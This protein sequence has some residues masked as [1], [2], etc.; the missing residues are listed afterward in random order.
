VESSSGG[1]RRRITSGRCSGFAV[2][3]TTAFLLF[4]LA[5]RAQ[6]RFRLELF[7]GNSWSAP[8]TLK[9]D[10]SGEERLSFRARWLTH[11]S[12]DAHYFAARV[13]L[14]SGRKGWELQF[15]HHKIYLTN[16]PAEIEK[17][18]VSHGWNLLTIQRASHGRILDW[19]IGA[20][21]VIAHAEGTIR[22]R[23]VDEG[24][25][26]FGHGYYVSGAAALMGVGKSVPIWRGFRANAEG[27]VTLSWARIP[28]LTGHAR[29][30][31][32]AFH[33]LFGLGF[34]I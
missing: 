7:S 13:A 22:G 28:I 18:E 14:W 10:Q 23:D 9:I 12:Q 16:P 21:P 5:A 33:L 30:T 20:G 8:S 34:G 29:T 27:H 15:L 32:A 31:N 3:L 4:P 19:R 6:D 1:S 2:A 25:G 11:P 17:F 24:N 26:L